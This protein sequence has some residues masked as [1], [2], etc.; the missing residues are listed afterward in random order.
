MKGVFPILY[1]LDTKKISLIYFIISLITMNFGFIYELFSH[2][3]YS[4]YMMFA[5]L[6]PFLL[7]TILFLVIGKL[8]LKVSNLSLNF[9]HSF[10]STL[11]LGCIMKG[12]LD[13]YGTTNSLLNIYLYVSILLLGLSIIFIRKS[14]T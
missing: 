2:G 8:K 14:S 7:G 1:T 11:T 12:F 9:Y 10:V 13:I 6:I 4:N 5:F 3:V